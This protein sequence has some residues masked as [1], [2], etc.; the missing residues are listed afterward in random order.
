[1][2]LEWKI[3]LQALKSE[4]NLE[5]KREWM[6]ENLS[7]KWRAKRKR[8]LKRE[9][10]KFVVKCQL[11]GMH[12]LDSQIMQSPV[13]LLNLSRSKILSIYVDVRIIPHS[14]VNFLNKIPTERTGEKIES[15]R[16]ESR[17][18]KCLSDSWCLFSLFPP[19]IRRVKNRKR[20][21]KRKRTE[22]IIIK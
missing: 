15:R 2:M 7:F 16:I 5:N 6:S 20:R 18:S 19:N 22:V 4:S 3:E 8:G 17:R 1:M 21:G 11:H 10:R 9:V 13:P 12:L 14:T